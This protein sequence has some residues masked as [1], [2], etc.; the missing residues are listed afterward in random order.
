MAGA[1]AAAGAGAGTSTSSNSSR[2]AAAGAAAR[3]PAAQTRLWWLEYDV[4]TGTLV[5][6]EK[7]EA[8]RPNPTWAQVSPDKQTV[9]FAR[10]HNLFMMDAKNFE[11][12]KKKADDPAIEEAQLTTD[13]ER[14]YG[15]AA[16]S[17]GG[18]TQDNQQQDGDNTTQE[19]DGRGAAAQ[20]ALDKK[21][22]PRTRSVGAVVGA[23][24]PQVLRARGPT[25]E[26]SASC[27]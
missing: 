12:A 26:R 25:R 24:Q 20:S 11:L 3:A 5:L 19:G 10:G 21:F 27:G 16:S 15:F 6:N 13:G 7:Y 1:A 17:Q 2:A 14:Y 9:I 18:Q 23:G 8:E 4:A 22:G